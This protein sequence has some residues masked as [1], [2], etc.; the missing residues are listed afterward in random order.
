[1]ISMKRHKVPKKWPVQRKGTTFVVRPSSNLKN[2]IPVLVILRDILKIAKTRK[3]V[4]RAVSSKAVLLNTKQ[5]RDEREAAQLFD[6]LSL[7]PSKKHYRVELGEN[8]KFKMK[9]ISE[10]ESKQK[11]SK[12][13]DKKILKGKKVQINLSDG[14]NFVSD[15]KCKTN[16]SALINLESK[17]IEKIVE[18]KEKT[19]TVVVAGKHTGKTG[20][21]EKINGEKKMVELKTDKDKLNVLIKQIMVVE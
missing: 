6:T 11:I 8:G 7:V 14:R 2:G 1:M 17:K 15:L 20:I 19:M 9:E 10:K 16:D 12:I 18:L 13:A 3:E 5:V 4:K 21:I